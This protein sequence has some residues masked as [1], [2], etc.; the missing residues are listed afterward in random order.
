MLRPRCT[1]PRFALRQA[2]PISVI[3]TKEKAPGE[4]GPH[5]WASALLH[6]EPTSSSCAS[7]G[8]G[9]LPESGESQRGGVC[10]AQD[11]DP[12]IEGRHEVCSRTVRHGPTQPRPGSGR[13]RCR[14]WSRQDGPY[15]LRGRGVGP[16]A[17]PAWSALRMPYRPMR[18]RYCQTDM[19]AVAPSPTAVA[20]RLPEPWR[21]SPA[22]KTPGMLV[23]SRS[24]S[25]SSGQRAASAADHLGPSEDEP[26][27]SSTMSF[28][29][30]PVGGSAP[31]KMKSAAAAR[32]PAGRWRDRGC[33]AIQV[34]IAM[35]CS[36]R[37]TAA[38]RR[39]SRRARYAPP[40]SATCPPRASRRARSW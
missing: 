33:R 1:A 3:P 32:F 6:H 11:D 39:C 12:V 28:A 36:D 19:T 24:G 30:Q 25:R 13:A 4:A 14:W 21:T 20:T 9:C 5:Q 23:S 22:A 40:G 31:I 10:Y 38:D 2:L 15:G 29:S 34:L 37:T 18:A 26:R 27:L 8:D 35:R 17:D 16:R 7:R